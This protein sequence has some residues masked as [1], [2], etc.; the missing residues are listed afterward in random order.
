M[1]WWGRYVGIAPNGQARIDYV[2]NEE[3]MNA[4]DERFI[5]KPLASSIK[6][7]VIYFAIERT[8]KATGDRIVFANV[9]LTRMEK[10]GY[11]MI[12]SMDESMGPGY[13]DCPKR[14]LDMLTSP[15]N[16]WAENWRQKCAERRHEK[17]HDQ[18]RKCP[19]GTKVVKD[20]TGAILEAYKY[21]SRKVFVDWNERRYCTAS[22]LRR[23]GYRIL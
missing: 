7:A 23:I 15:S 14:I 20:D 13:Y 1:G 19:I 9:C 16:A 4:E 8:E 5:W 17:A 22:Q 10:N 11:L 18:L 2:I 3:G 12:K 21:R 6:G